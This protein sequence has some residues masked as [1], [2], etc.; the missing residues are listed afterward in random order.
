[1][2]KYETRYLRQHESVKKDTKIMNN[3]TKEIIIGGIRL[4]GIEIKKLIGEV[5]S[6]PSAK[7]TDFDYGVEADKKAEKIII[8]AI[9]KSGLDC[10]IISE[11]SGIIGKKG[12]EYRVFI[13]PL[14]GSVN[15]SRDIPGF[16]VG[17]GIYS[18]ENEPLLGIIY[19]PNLDELFIGEKGK[20]VILNGKRVSPKTYKKNILINLEWFGAD[21]Y[22]DVAEKLK[23]ANL[24]ARTA[25]SGVLALCYGVIGRGDASVLL[26]NYPWDIAPGMVFA[27]ELGYVIKQLDGNEVDLSKNKQ[28]II[29]APQGL[30]KKI[31]DCLK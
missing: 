9:N 13:D 19:D 28:D 5:S 12:A 15:F 3:Q 8:D 27:R 10:E 31:S 18:S 30:F 22:I 29:A 23:K 11:E 7:I 21:N 24:R 14:D 4:A 25:G 1:M 17:L 16:C 2:E 20:G 26:Q 6:I